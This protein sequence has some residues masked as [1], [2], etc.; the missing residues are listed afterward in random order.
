M[1]RTKHVEGRIDVDVEGIEP[2]VEALAER[3]AGRGPAGRMYDRV[4]LAECLLRRREEP[5]RGIGVSDVTGHEDA[6]W[7]LFFIIFVLTI[8]NWNARR[9]WVFEG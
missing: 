2:V 1:G 5:G 4:E 7:V 9:R 6:A 3:G 8:I